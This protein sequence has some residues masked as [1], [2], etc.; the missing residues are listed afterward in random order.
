MS[1]QDCHERFVLTSIQQRD[2]IK[3]DGGAPSGLPPGLT[4]LPVDS[5]QAGQWGEG[6][7]SLVGPLVPVNPGLGDTVSLSS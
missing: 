2:N 3:G 5:Q 6:V 7:T 1:F 4:V